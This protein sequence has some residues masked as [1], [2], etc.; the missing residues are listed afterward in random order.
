MAT[1]SIIFGLIVTT[2]L[3]IIWRMYRKYSFLL[4][5]YKK[6]LQQAHHF[7]QATDAE[8]TRLIQ[9]KLDLEEVVEHQRGVITNLRRAE[10]KHIATIK[11]LSGD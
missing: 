11:K 4:S 6:T 9:E 1:S 2:L 5:M 10:R 8:I 7:K 3:F